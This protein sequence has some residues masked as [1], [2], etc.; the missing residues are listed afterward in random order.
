MSAIIALFFLLKR[1]V[2]RKIF[3]IRLSVGK[4]EDWSDIYGQSLFHS[5]EAKRWEVKKYTLQGEPSSDET[6]ASNLAET[7]GNYMTKL[8]EKAK[9]L[10]ASSAKRILRRVSVQP[11]ATA[12][13]V[14][15][16]S[17][18][19]LD[20][21]GVGS[22]AMASAT[23]YTSLELP[24]APQTG[25]RDLAT[26]SEKQK[27]ALPVPSEK[28]QIPAAGSR[29]ATLKSTADHA[30]LRARPGSPSAFLPRSPSPTWEQ[31]RMFASE[32]PIID[33]DELSDVPSEN[34]SKVVFTTGEEGKE[35]LAAYCY[36]NGWVKIEK[37]VDQR[38]ANKWLDMQESIHSKAFLSAGTEAV[39]TQA[40]GTSP[41]RLSPTL[42][43]FQED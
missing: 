14:D 2:E 33:G 39:A 8:K 13:K 10:G 5:D 35:V 23:S 20:M 31:T 4:T 21:D 17:P 3:H 41:G 12:Q 34:A 22:A 30:E 32:G 40:A 1:L 43:G 15:G 19:Y 27:K 11:E 25:Q 36:G 7:A 6:S 24:D 9:L 42:E 38:T 18:S 16:S 28:L 37:F 26:F 29:S